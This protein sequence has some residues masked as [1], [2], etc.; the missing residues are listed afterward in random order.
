MIRTLKLFFIF[1]IIA[2]QTQLFAQ[3]DTRLLLNFNFHDNPEA[4]QGKL[5]F[6]VEAASQSGSQPIKEFHGSLT[7]NTEL[8]NQK[9]SVTFTNPRAFASFDYNQTEETS[10][11][12]IN[13]SYILIDGHSSASITE[14]WS[15]IVKI[16]IIYSMS[17]GIGEIDW[18][19]YSVIKTDDTNIT[20]N[21]EGDPALGDISLPVQ[22]S[23]FT[24]MYTPKEG[25]EL[26][27][28][29]QSE[30]NCA[31]FHI[32]RAA[33]REG[34][35]ATITTALIPGQ[36]NTSAPTEYTYT[37]MNV[38]PEQTY[39][40]RIQ[41]V[42][43]DQEGVAKDFYGPL[44]VETVPMAIPQTLLL[45]PNYPNPFNPGTSIYFEIPE[46]SNVSLVIY[47][48]LGK[49]VRT[50]VNEEREAQ[51]YYETWDGKDNRGRDVEAGIYFYRL[52]AGT[53]VRVRKM[54][55]VE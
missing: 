31:G 41:V 7:M 24:A 12:N 15:S 17:S 3:I 30:T 55:K 35:Y 33:E 54:I 36:G 34:D 27:W 42:S 6:T 51:P 11:A 29:T 25:V 13:Y 40:Y 52:K 1:C 47:N 19:S 22:M 49:E 32:Q 39:W 45:A 23:Q 53:D 4:G 48:L 16:E 46:Q 44:R 37:D 9:I 20:G 8:S 14:S 26:A 38:A 18:N 5:I 28:T 50:L 43:T 21:T 10:G 2:F